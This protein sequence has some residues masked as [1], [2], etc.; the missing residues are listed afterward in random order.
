M[1][2]NSYI[3]VHCILSGKND[4]QA[5]TKSTERLEVILHPVATESG[6]CYFFMPIYRFNYKTNILIISLPPEIKEEE[7][8]TSTVLILTS[9]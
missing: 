6:G 3:T 9:Q 7:I 4:L 8:S 5:V 2:K 1:Q